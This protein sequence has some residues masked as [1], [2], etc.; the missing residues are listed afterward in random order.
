MKSTIN[1]VQTKAFKYLFTLNL[2]LN[3]KLFTLFLQHLYNRFGHRSKVT[4]KTLPCSSGLRDPSTLPWHCFTKISACRLRRK[5]PLN[6]CTGLAPWV[7]APKDSFDPR[8]SWFS[9]SCSGTIF[10]FGPHL[11]LTPRWVAVFAFLLNSDFRQIH[12]SVLPTGPQ[13]KPFLA[14]Y[15]QR[16]SSGWVFLLF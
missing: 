6:D 2:R 16:C 7:V 3:T 5:V 10:L 8:P 9:P 14:A 11:T 12:A 4:T 13:K 1:Y 15:L